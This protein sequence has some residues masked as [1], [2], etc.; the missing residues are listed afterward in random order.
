MEVIEMD[1]GLLI[2]RIVVGSLMIGHGTQKLFGWFG[3][4]GLQGTGGFFQSLGYPAGAA[5]ALMAG[6]AEAGGGLLLALGFFTPI[7]AAAV[8]GVMV[9]T[10]V[11]VH[12]RNG[13]W[14]TA[15]GYEYTLVL[16]AVSAG[17]AFTGAGVFS[18][19]DALGW[20]LSGVL[21]GTAAIALGVGVSFFPLA[22]RTVAP[23]AP[24]AQ[25]E[26]G[27]RAA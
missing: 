9:N 12:W 3:G 22:A 13:P 25:T 6:T 27:R 7:G 19:D 23:A 8:I 20:D 24:G 2:V 10:I 16:A 15:G 18:L 21:W 1:V 14:I 26:Q 4:H 5:M 11:A 17:L